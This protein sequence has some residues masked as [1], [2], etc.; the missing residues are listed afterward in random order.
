M[1]RAWERRLLLIETGMLDTRSK[2][3]VVPIWEEAGHRLKVLAKPSFGLGSLRSRKD[4]LAFSTIAFLTLGLLYAAYRPTTYTASSEL[5]VYIRQIQTGA[6]LAIL[7]GRADL[8]LVQNQIELLRSGNVLIKTV[9]TL[10]LYQDA[11]FADEY[12]LSESD[13]IPSAGDKGAAFGAALD[14]LRRK[15]RVRQVGTSHIITVAY[16]A[17]EPAKAARVLNTVIRVYLEELIRASD[18]GSPALRELYQSLGPSAFLVSDAQPPIRPDG[19]PTVLIAIGAALFGFCVG[20]AVAIL[21]D[22]MNDT[23][24]SARQVECA[25][26]M[27]C[28]GVIRRRVDKGVVAEDVTVHHSFALEHQE[29]RRLSATTLEA[30]LHDVR[31]IGV[32]STVPGEGAT[33]LAIGLAQA[34]AAAGKRVLLVDGVPESRSVSRWA[35]NLSRIPVWSS[36]GPRL[37]VLDGIVEGRTGL[38]VLPLRE[39]SDGDIYSVDPALP[40]GILDSAAGSYDLVIVDMPALVTG[41]DVRGAAQSLDGFLLVVKWGATESELVRQAL[42]SA[43]EARSKFVGAVLNMADDDVMR[44]YGYEPAAELKV[45]TAS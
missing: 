32:T 37:G 23:I 29:L 40:D 44:C 10:K 39:P 15:L 14:T 28:L 31:T 45:A 11:E 25:L 41:P 30:S 20:A 38:H 7:P 35:V 43:G 16:K 33:T 18:T 22:A 9:E 19:L 1:G 21:R 4:L 13:T 2:P 24:R 27:E 3:P 6:D 5:L 26:G 12:A 34:I 36:N 42:R 17:S 8:P